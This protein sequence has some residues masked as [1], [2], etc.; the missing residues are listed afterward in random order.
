MMLKILLEF[1]NQRHIYLL[2]IIFI[3]DTIFMRYLYRMKQKFHCPRCG[4]K[5]II[6]YDDFIE[7]PKCDL[8]FDK[9]FLGIIP[10]EDILS[11][12]ELIAFTDAFVEKDLKKK[13]KNNSPF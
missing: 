6:E 8:E 1:I 9:E 7:C 3:I 12:Q 4:S 5:N 2:F 13:K 10:D 11:R